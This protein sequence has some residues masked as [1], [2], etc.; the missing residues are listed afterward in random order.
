MRATRREGPLVAT[1]TVDYTSPR[2]LED[3][4]LKCRVF[5]HNWDDNPNA[6]F[7]PA[8]WRTSAGAVALRC[9]RCTMERYDYIGKD[10]QVASRRYKAPKGY[11]KMSHDDGARPTLR[12][13]LF[14]RSLLVHSYKRRA[15]GK[16]GSN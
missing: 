8:L 2:D 5:G 15:N 16:G 10:M 4:Y 13:E 1:A 9:E 11:S 12:R 6:E 3:A 14:R 7:S